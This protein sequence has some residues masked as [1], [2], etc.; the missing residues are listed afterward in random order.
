MQYLLRNCTLAV[1][2]EECDNFLTTRYNKRAYP[3]YMVLRSRVLD[4]GGF[5]FVFF[6]FPP[7]C[8]KHAF[9]KL[10]FFFSPTVIISSQ[11]LSGHTIIQI[12]RKIHAEKAIGYVDMTTFFF[13]C[14]YRGYF[15]PLR[16]Q[17][18]YCI[19]RGYIIYCVHRGVYPLLHLQG[20]IYSLFHLYQCSY[21]GYIFFLFISTSP[22]HY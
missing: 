5:L 19:C 2:I 15:F 3:L 10:P 11:Q 20:V 7:R 13:Y 16:L 21:R 8:Y 4:V 22:V 1:Y 14:D 12:R 18:V 9:L 6:Y 17:G